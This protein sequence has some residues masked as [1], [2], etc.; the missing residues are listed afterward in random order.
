[1]KMKMIMM[2]TILSVGICKRDWY[3]HQ[4]GDHM[5]RS[6]NKNGDYDD[7]WGLHVDHDDE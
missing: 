6:V 3:D 2:I 1:M 7:Y 5:S 4:S